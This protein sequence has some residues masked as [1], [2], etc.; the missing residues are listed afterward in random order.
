MP[1]FLIY[2]YMVQV[3]EFS[4][5]VCIRRPQA[6]GGYIELPTDPG[7]GIEIDESKFEKYPYRQLP[8]RKIRTVED[9]RNWH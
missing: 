3:D 9:E 1:N 5:D 6:E 4:D 7:L 8:P 2:E